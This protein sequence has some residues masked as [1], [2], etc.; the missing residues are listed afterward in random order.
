MELGRAKTIAEEVIKRLSPYCQRIEIA[1]SVRRN[2]PT[3]RDIDLVLIPSDPWN[4]SH[5]IMGLG[6]SSLKGEKLKRV[7]YN[8]IQ[9]DLYYATPEAWATLLLIRTGSK[10]NNIRL[11]MLAKKK[12]WHLAASGAGLFNEKGQRVAGGSEESIYEALEL[13]YQEPWERN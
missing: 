2:K 11:A 7:T 12:G 5:E 4:L 9:I 10:E 6:P 3:V 13:P 1:G 8:G